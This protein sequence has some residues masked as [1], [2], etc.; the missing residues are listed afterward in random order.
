MENRFKVGLVIV[1]PLLIVAVC[2][3]SSQTNMI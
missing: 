3:L 1:V 2:Q